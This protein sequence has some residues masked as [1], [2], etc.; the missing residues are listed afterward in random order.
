MVAVVFMKNAIRRS[1]THRWRSLGFSAG[2][3]TNS[4]ICSLFL[5]NKKAA[6]VEKAPQNDAGLKESHLRS[7]I[8]GVTWRILGTIDTIVISYFITGNTK[9]AVSIGGIEVF[10]KIFLYYLHE[11]LWQIA[12]RG[13]L[14]AWIKRIF[15]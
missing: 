15:K 13:T 11:R 6:S 3:F 2:I 4:I 9:H 1:S 12:P 7:V 10:T 5:F 14:C 8:K